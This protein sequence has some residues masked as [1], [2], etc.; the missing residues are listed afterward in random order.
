M[1]IRQQQILICLS[2]LFTVSCMNAQDTKKRHND[3]LWMSMS[4]EYA[5]V[6]EQVYRMAWPI[7]K[8]RARA[9]ENDWI[10]VF[11]VDETVLDNSQYARERLAVDSVFTQQSWTAWVRREEAPFI[12]GA[13]A[14]ID[15]VRS[16]GAKAHVGFIT[17]RMIFNEAATTANLRKVGLYQDGDPVLC[18]ENKE[19][20]K[21]DRRKC[22]E[23]GTGR[24]QAYG[25]RVLLA[26][27]GDNIRDFM[28]MRGL[29]NAQKYRHEDLPADERWG[30]KYFILPNPNYGSW[31]RDYR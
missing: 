28:P 4:V 5:A 1:K 27:F 10:V 17:N 6:C 20:K 2:L 26:L 24:C 16:L 22:L 25:P 31:E 3:I 14:F 11:D 13:K 8:Q 15:S 18:R 19:D 23:S 29:E 12:P 30:T 7:V 9:E 21:E